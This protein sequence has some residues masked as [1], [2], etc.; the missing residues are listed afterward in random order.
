[1][2]EADQQMRYPIS[3]AYRQQFRQVSALQDHLRRLNG[4]L[5]D[6]S[7][8]LEHQLVNNAP[9]PDS[10]APVTETPDVQGMADNDPAPP[11]VM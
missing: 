2:S 7:G 10:T 4:E 9:A 5:M 6:F 1:M 8:G 11:S 3:Y